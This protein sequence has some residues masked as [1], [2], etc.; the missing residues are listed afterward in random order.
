MKKIKK[1]KNCKGLKNLSVGVYEI[2]TEK[3]H[4]TY[5]EVANTLI[6]KLKR[7]NKE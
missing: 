1:S 6:E 4:T 7:K 5:K 2:V 3:G